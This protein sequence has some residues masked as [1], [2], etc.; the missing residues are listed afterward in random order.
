MAMLGSKRIH[1]VYT[2]SR[3]CGVEEIIEKNN[4][5][6]EYM[7]VVAYK[8]ASFNKI[9]SSAEEHLKGHDEVSLVGGTT[10]VTTKN[11]FTKQI[12]FEWGQNLDLQNH[13]VK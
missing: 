11:S 9:A 2:D 6:G 7:K 13:L 3:G 10:E 5:K 12:S 8:R 1:M 4:L